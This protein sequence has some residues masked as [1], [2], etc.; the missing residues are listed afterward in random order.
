MIKLN[1]KFNQ[2]QTIRG[3][4]I[5][6][7]AN[8]PRQFITLT[9]WPFCLTPWPWTFLVHVFKFCTKFEWNWKMLLTIYSRPLFWGAISCM[10]QIWW[11]GPQ[12]QIT[13]QGHSIFRITTV[14]FWHFNSHHKHSVFYHILDLD[15]SWSYTRSLSCKILK[16]IS[17]N[18]QIWCS[19]RY[20]I[21]HNLVHI[22]GTTFW[23]F[24]K[25]LW[26][27]YP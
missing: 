18:L 3:K 16:G 9:S 24:M 19:V 25:I 13:G 27:M 22:S 11:K 26:Q 23:I 5:D 8:F 2:N 14:P 4:V 15:Q 17:T 6:D 21:F 12:N 20:G 1:H 10:D 7:L